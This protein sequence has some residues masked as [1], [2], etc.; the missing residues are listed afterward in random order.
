VK[1]SKDDYEVGYGKPPK[2]GQF[3]PGESGNPKGRPVEDQR[4]RLKNEDLQNY[5]F[6]DATEKVTVRIGGVDVEMDKLNAIIKQV[7]VKA[8]KGD[9]RAYKEYFKWYDRLSQK[10]DSARLEILEGVYRFRE[11]QEQEMDMKTP[12]ERWETLCCGWKIRKIE[13]ER[14]GVEELPYECEE[15]VDEEDWKH[16]KQHM[17]NVRQGKDKPGDWPPKYWDEEV[18]ENGV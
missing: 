6:Q 12:Q 11:R 7:G 3:K 18:P 17:E 2:S 9:A 16:F 15:P 5:F 14:G 4:I 13:R 8:M 10:S 1:M